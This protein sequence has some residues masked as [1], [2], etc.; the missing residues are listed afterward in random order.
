MASGKMMG[1][2]AW[3]VAG[4]LAIGLVAVAFM[5]YQ[6]SIRTAGMGEA[7]AQV[8]STVGEEEIDPGEFKDVA[9]R[10]E[11]AQ[12]AQEAI[13]GMRM[14]LA[15]AGD[16]LTAARNEATTARSEAAASAQRILDLEA[17]AEAHAQALEEKAGEADAA[18]AEA[19]QAVQKA[20][21][22][23]AEAEKAL[24]RLKKEKNAEIKR[25]QSEIQD[26]NAMAE[27]ALVGEEEV[28]EDMTDVIAEVLAETKERNEIVEEGRFIGPSQMFSVIRYS[29]D[30]T[31][32]FNLLDGQTLTYHDVPPDVVENLI[33]TSDRLDLTFRFRIQ[34]EYRCLP[35]DR[36]VIR[37]YWKWLRRHRTRA[38]VRYIGPEPEEVPAEEPESGAAG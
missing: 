6:Q 23:K 10:T 22:E 12:E 3:S 13:R 31:L 2:V 27:D 8:I 15:S 5:A 32:L 14:E 25:L 34:G 24:D 37:K 21:G 38:E 29:E 18:R 9:R 7:L 17:Q 35:P 26:M 20:N 4:V 1:I 28:G 11:I 33:S 19:E 16:A 30:R 36:V